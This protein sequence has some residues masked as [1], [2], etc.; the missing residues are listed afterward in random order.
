[1]S[2]VS[3]CLVDC[4]FAHYVVCDVLTLFRF[5]L[6]CH[7]ALLRLFPRHLQQCNRSV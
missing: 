5:S 1:M 4:F 2:L 7:S 3:V 6:V